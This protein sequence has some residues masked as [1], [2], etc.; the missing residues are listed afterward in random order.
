MEAIANYQK[1]TPKEKNQRKRHEQREKI[2]RPKSLDLNQKQQEVKELIV[3]DRE[4]P[5]FFQR[6]HRILTMFQYKVSLNT[7]LTSLDSA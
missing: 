5:S 1:N 3:D 7:F 4:D 2:I 6:F